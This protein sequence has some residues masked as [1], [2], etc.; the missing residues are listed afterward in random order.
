[1]MDAF[2]K[3]KSAQSELGPGE[4]C[5]PDEGSSNGQKKAKQ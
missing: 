1:M 4:H 5:D 2:Q 3:I